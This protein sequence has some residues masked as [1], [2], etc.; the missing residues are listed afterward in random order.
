[1]T[2]T[3]SML[4]LLTLLT[5]ACN[6]SGGGGSD[7]KDSAPATEVTDTPPVIPEPEPTPTPPDTCEEKV[8]ATPRKLKGLKPITAEEISFMEKHNKVK[9]IKGVRLNRMGLS[10]INE[11]RIKA[12]LPKLSAS[13]SFAAGE[14]T[15]TEEEVSSE[16]VGAL[17][18]ALDNSTLPSFPAIGQQSVNNCAAWAMG[19]YQWSHNTGLALGWNNKTS[20][21][22]RCSPKFIYNMINDG[23]DEG[24][25]FSDALKMV[26][27]H[28]CVSWNSFPENSDYRSWDTNPDHWKAAIPYRSAAFQYVSNVDTATGLNQVKQLLNNGYV[29]TYGTYIES[30]QFTTIKVNPSANSNPLAGQSVLRYMNGTAG[31]HA[32]TIVGYD[33]NAWTDINQNNVVDSGE[34]GVL[35]IA[36][37][38]GTSW[39]NGG[40]SFVAYDALKSVSGVSG[41]PSAG[42]QPAFMSRQV[43]H[44]PV[45]ASSG[46]AYTP[47]YLA[48]FTVNHAARNQLSVKFG[49]STSTYTPF[50]MI[51]KGGTN[52]FSGTVIMDVS[53]LS[54]PSTDK[55]FYLTVT[56]KTSGSPATVSSFEI[57]DLVNST[58]SAS[59]DLVTATTVDAAS[60]TFRVNFAT[61][62]PNSAPTARMLAS[63]TTGF[64]PLLVQFEG[65]GSSD[66]DGTIVSYSWNFGDG[67]TGSGI[68]PDKTF[69]R[70]GR[71][72]VTLTVKDNDGSTSTTSKVISVNQEEEPVCH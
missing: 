40:Y 21:V 18:A 9:K 57:I 11:R 20:S 70:T 45:R 17:P 34:L 64:A 51:N 19:Y 12:G 13:E 7:S 10:R 33:D 4:F 32:M 25:Y 16:L 37:S 39:K 71:F 69:T 3:L 72:T 35:K 62:V 38:W 44:M 36:N 46:S 31:G 28:G 48:K 1:M 27:K 5:T 8:G 41:G 43:Y 2:K 67:T 22:N 56:D 54:V 59:P 63:V 42:R 15:T 52:S 50:A 30:W 26:E 24:A 53:D 55:S 65:S 49:T 66:P 6:K 58:Q 61:T 68:S 14:D 23:V 60:K 29:L 47:K